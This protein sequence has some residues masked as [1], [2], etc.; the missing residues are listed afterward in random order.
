[1]TDYKKNIIIKKKKIYCSNCGRYGH[2]YV[3]C[4]EPITS[5]GII[6]LKIDDQLFEKH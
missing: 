4:N 5:L 3:K 2:K 1:M 6:A